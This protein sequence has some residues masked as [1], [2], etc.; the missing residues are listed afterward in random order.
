MDPA[1]QAEE[2]GANVDLDAQR[3]GKC[4]V[5]KTSTRQV[6]VVHILE[7]WFFVTVSNFCVY[8]I[9]N[10][11]FSC[12]WLAWWMWMHLNLQIWSVS[13]KIHT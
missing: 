11:P 10:R 12:P 13:T 8:F 2:E 1:D 3:K 4:A 9:L 6:M 7:Q 5:I